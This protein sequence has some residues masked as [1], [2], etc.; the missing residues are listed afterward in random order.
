ISN[1]KQESREESI[2]NIRSDIDSRLMEL[3]AKIDLVK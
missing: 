3:Q 2:L 1:E